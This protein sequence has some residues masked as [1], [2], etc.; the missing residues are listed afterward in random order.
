MFSSDGNSTASEIKILSVITDPL[1]DVIVQLNSTVLELWAQDEC[2][3]CTLLK[4]DCPVDPVEEEFFGL[5]LLPFL[6][7]EAP[8]TKP[9]EFLFNLGPFYEWADWEVGLLLLVISLFILCGALVLMVKVLNSL[10]KGKTN[11]I[12]FLLFL[13]HYRCSPVTHTGTCVKHTMLYSKS[14]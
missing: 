10:L 2:G 9:C 4:K 13:L 8:E 14:A 3:N 6:A 12:F 11:H 7:T 5:G 1:V